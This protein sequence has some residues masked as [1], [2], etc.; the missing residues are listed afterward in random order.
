MLDGAEA[1]GE[2]EAGK[3]DGAWVSVGRGGKGVEG[4]HPR[5]GE[6]TGARDII[7]CVPVLRVVGE[8]G[9]VL[10]SGRRADQ[11]VRSVRGG[12]RAKLRAGIRQAVQSG[13]RTARSRERNSRGWGH[14][15]LGGETVEGEQERG[16]EQW[17]WC[18]LLCDSPQTQSPNG[19]KVPLAPCTTPSPRGRGHSA[20]TRPGS[21]SLPAL[22]AGA[23]ASP[24]RGKAASPSPAASPRLKARGNQNRTPPKT[25]ASRGADDSPIWHK[26]RSIARGHGHA[27]RR[28]PCRATEAGGAGR[29][30]PCPG[31]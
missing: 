24:E 9:D 29:R 8:T 26:P 28:F 1:G 22:G 25:A 30:I 13:R 4:V 11:R 14:R 27:G 7:A 3:G 23:Y 16:G 17:A 10:A 15:R 12:A 2:G 18:V 19:P 31:C 21:R 5:E 6:A 20:L